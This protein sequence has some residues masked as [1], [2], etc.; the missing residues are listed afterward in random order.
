MYGKLSYLFARKTTKS[1]A[2]ATLCLYI[3]SVF[4]DEIWLDVSGVCAI[5][6][7]ATLPGKIMFLLITQYGDYD[8]H[9]A[10]YGYHYAQ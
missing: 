1:P 4:L 3:F 10:H 6:L 9:Y 5:F 8:N 7:D 2:G